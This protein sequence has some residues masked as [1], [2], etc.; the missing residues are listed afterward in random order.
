MLNRFIWCAYGS[1]KWLMLMV[2]RLVVYRVSSAWAAVQRFLMG[3]GVMMRSILGSSLVR[4]FVVLDETSPW[5]FSPCLYKRLIDLEPVDYIKTKPYDGKVS[6]VLVTQYLIVTT[7]C[8]AFFFLCCVQGCNGQPYFALRLQF[9]YEHSSW[10]DGIAVEFTLKFSP[11]S[12]FLEKNI[13]MTRQSPRKW[14]KVTPSRPSRLGRP[15]STC[16]SSPI[17]PT[18]SLWVMPGS[19]RALELGIEMV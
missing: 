15:V 19:W 5:N 10:K 8:I 17:C 13:Q 7:L 3:V 18:S 6:D 14:D 1:D 12:V 16:L 2:V 11:N 4:S 9:P